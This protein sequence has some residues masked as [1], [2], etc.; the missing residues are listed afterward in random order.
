MAQI[1]RDIGTYRA[2]IDEITSEAQKG[3]SEGAAVDPTKLNLLSEKEKEMR[4][5]LE[6]FEHSSAAEQGKIQE[7]QQ[8][9][10][11]VLSS[12][13]TFRGRHAW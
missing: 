11:Q 8:Q 10:L 12:R 4:S 5:Y 2:S 1:K 6:D 13:A 3:G 9:I 7:S